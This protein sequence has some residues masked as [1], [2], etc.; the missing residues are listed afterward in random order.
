MSGGE[1]LPDDGQLIRPDIDMLH[2]SPT[3]P[4][5]SFDGPA[6]AELAESIKA[7]G[8]M[9]PILCRVMPPELA[10]KL[11]T[12][13]QLEL[14]AGERRWRASKIAG[15][16][17]VPVLLRDLTDTQVQTLQVVENLQR[18]GL[19]SVEEAEGFGQLLAGGMSADEIAQQ[20][21]KSLGYIYAK[22]KL[23]ALCPEARDAL[24][25]GQLIESTAVLIARIPVPALQIDALNV[26]TARDA[27][28]GEPMTFRRAKLHIETSYTKNLAKAP[29]D[30]DDTT[31][32]CA[33]ACRECPHNLRNAPESDTSANVCTDLTCYDKKRQEHN[34]RLLNLPDDTPRIDIPR[35]PGSI[36][37]PINWTDYDAAGYRLLSSINYHDAR[38]TGSQRSYA[39]W[40]AD[41]GES[42][43]IAIHTD[44]F[45]G[46]VRL[47]ASKADLIAAAERI[48]QA[49]AQTTEQLGLDIATEQPAPTAPA[50]A[51][52]ERPA[53]PASPERKPIPTKL[54]VAPRDS[55][56]D[57]L[58]IAY[59]KYRQAIADT[60]VSNPPL[61]IAGPLL[62]MIARYALKTDIEFESDGLAMASLLNGL[63]SQLAGTDRRALSPDT[64]ELMADA[65]GIDHTA[66]LNKHVPVPEGCDDGY[67]IQPPEA[68]AC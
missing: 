51:R 40:L 57:A 5:K 39:D 31:L 45:T 12:L 48:A 35:A 6:L 30:I 47:I 1:T 61:M 44:P 32:P 65:I 16:T 22:R 13:A 43:P 58:K 68:S 7:N 42:V 20:V 10:Q 29:F 54:T 15:L 3:N 60:I 4:R 49:Q 36:G 27:D 8:V 21:G 66:L 64:I 50:P 17:D 62:H 41:N 2:P 52:A 37:G 18:E 23:L 28:S 53:A 46:D 25:S 19:N 9:T 67:P 34:I 26:V 24:R 33:P 59:I 38:P 56:N 14:V 11:N 63:A 55:A